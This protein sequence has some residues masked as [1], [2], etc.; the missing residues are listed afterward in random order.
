MNGAHFN[1]TLHGKTHN[2]A[3]LKSGLWNVVPRDPFIQNLLNTDFSLSRY[4]PADGDP[5]IAAVSDA[6]KRF[7]V[8]PV[9]PPIKPA[10]EGAI[11]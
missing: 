1:V 4:G 11:Y 2:C 3:I 7:K 5:Y 10:P 8:K 9:L 6:A